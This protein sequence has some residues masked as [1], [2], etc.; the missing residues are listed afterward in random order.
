MF[1]D[2]TL[3]TGESKKVELEY[4][5]LEKH[6]FLCKA[7]THEK[8]DCPRRQDLEGKV[9]EPKNINYSRTKDSL[10]AF[11]RA[12]D[13]KKADRS[14]APHVFDRE[15]EDQARYHRR[16][17]GY[18]TPRAPRPRSP[19]RSYY[20]E[21]SHYHRD[22]PLESLREKERTS[23][24]S[25]YGRVG[26][27]THVS[28]RISHGQVSVHSRLGDRVWVE[29]GSQSQISHTPP[30]NPPREPMIIRQE[31]NSSLERRPVLE[32]LALPVA[33]TL[34]PDGDDLNV[35]KE[36]STQERMSALQRLTPPSNARVPL[37]LNGVANSDSGRLQEVEVQYLE[38]T[39]PTHILNTSGGPSSSRHPAR[40]RLTL[41][42][43]SPIR[44]LSGDR[45][46][47]AEVNMARVTEEEANLNNS[48]LQQAPPSKA[49]KATNSKATGKRKASER[50]PPKRR[51]AH[52][53]LQGVNLKKR[54]VS[55]VQNSPRGKPSN[56]GVG[57]LLLSWKDHVDLEILE[58]CPNFIDVKLTI[59]PE[60]TFV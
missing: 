35:Q 2:I 47:L 48:N 13:E 14:R 28:Q 17:E 24:I 30:P 43:E 32:R 60:S 36:P 7:L 12:K 22:L 50:P 25:K 37:L 18:E 15:R 52:S 27:R 34:L 21:R 6:C 58:S 46:H 38:D 31:V 29:K 53:P 19:T 57:G 16:G 20:S 49:R 1:L 9:V 26:Q 5:K 33:R 55:K 11:R 44:S 41:P 4:E 45:R 8:E 10:D 59:G 42:Q 3:P 23:S 54:R 51:V 56:K 40:E 39:F